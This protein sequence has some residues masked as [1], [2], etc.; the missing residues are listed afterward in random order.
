MWD[1]AKA[2]NGLSATL[3]AM[4]VLALLAAFTLW[5]VRH[6]V[7]AF[8]EVVVV[9]PLSRASPL[10]LEAIIRDELTGTFFTL[11]LER[12]RA[13]IARVPWVRSAALRRQWP[14]RLE[15]AIEEHQPLARLGEGTLVNTE[16]E[17]FVANHVGE[18]P[19]FEG[20]DAASV[21][22][23][24][25]YRAWSDR[26]QP[27]ALA[28]DGIRV[29]SRGGWEIVAHD[30][31]GTLTVELGRDEVDARLERFVVAYARTLGSLARAGTRIELVDLRY[32]N[33]FS[34]KVP[35]FREKSPR[36]AT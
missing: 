15:V 22:M 14:P 17:V 10:Q 25:R 32:R 11:N 6:S 16:G 4:A 24:R 35:S 23:T 36:K 5:L 13:A 8:R 2:L 27:L 33:G 20:P 7:F 28:V 34:A 9:T 18:L 12:T 26:L 3:F 29:S 31:G 21:E 1:D 19:R 30:G